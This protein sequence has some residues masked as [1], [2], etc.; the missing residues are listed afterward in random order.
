M[1]FERWFS[2]NYYNLKSK[3]YLSILL[4]PIPLAAFTS[5]FLLCFIPWHQQRANSYLG[6]KSET[7]HYLHDSISATTIFE[8][9]LL[10]GDSRE[11]DARL[12]SS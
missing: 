10:T 9:S 6:F 4:L 2:Y 5:H 1:A 3:K 12:S 11:D 8:I 7:F